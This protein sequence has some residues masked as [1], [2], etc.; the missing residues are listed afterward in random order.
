MTGAN[1]HLVGYAYYIKKYR[2]Y[3]S[4]YQSLGKE[5]RVSVIGIW[6]FENCFRYQQILREFEFATGGVICDNKL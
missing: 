5:E 3:R 1:F 6:I 4:W 2:Y